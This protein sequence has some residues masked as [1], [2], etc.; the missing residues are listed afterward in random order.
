MTIEDLFDR[1]DNEAERALVGYPLDV[2]AE[3]ELE[4][5]PG[6]YPIVRGELVRIERIGAR[7]IFRFEVKQ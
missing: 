5:L 3:I 2:K 6:Q 7:V 4:S 1:I